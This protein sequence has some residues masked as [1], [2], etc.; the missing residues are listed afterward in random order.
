MH[1]NLLR[2]AFGVSGA[3]YDALC[4]CRPGLKL[5]KVAWHQKKL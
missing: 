4:N 3:A 1:R 2:Q 5:A